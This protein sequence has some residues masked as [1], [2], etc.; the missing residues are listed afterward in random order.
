M[1]YGLSIIFVSLAIAGFWADSFG[2]CAEADEPVI[3]GAVPDFQFV[4]ERG[5][6]FGLDDLAGRVW[7][8]DFIFTRC[9]GICPLMSGQFSNL[10]AK[11]PPEVQ[12]VS[13]SVD[14]VHDRPEVLS[15]YARRF[16][17]AS[18][19]W[20]FLTGDEKTMWNF[21]SE[22]FHLGLEKA[23]EEDLKAGAQPI[24][25][26]NR[27]VLVDQAGRIRGYYDSSEPEKL[28]NLIRDVFSL[29][30]RGAVSVPEGE[31]APPLHLE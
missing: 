10:Q 5:G 8:A 21:I 16:K 11:L 19:R 2:R 3:Y 25:H 4:D 17:A 18:G 23:T 27:F 31:V 22:G 9:Q 20:H 24:M 7:I 12:L 28:G 1:K 29:M 6:P 13:F 26:S 14:P 15:E 30:S